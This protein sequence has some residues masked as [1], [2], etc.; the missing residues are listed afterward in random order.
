MNQI[1]IRGIETNM[2]AGDNNESHI[3]GERG[4]RELG[5]KTNKRGWDK[6]D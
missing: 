3:L 1:G 6:L 5:I 4:V 2:G